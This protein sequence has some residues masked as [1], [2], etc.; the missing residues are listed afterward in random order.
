M[1]SRRTILAAAAALP[2][3]RVATARAA[4]P[5][6]AG[7]RIAFQLVRHGDVIGRHELAF[8]SDGASLVV[9]IAV[10]IVVKFGPIPVYRYRHRGTERWQGDRFAGFDS[11]TDS[12]GTPHHM[13]AVA[14]G[15]TITVEGSARP[16]Y[17]APAH[18]LPSTY[19]NPAMLQRHV[20]SSEDGQ[21]FDVTPQK[22]GDD[23]VRLAAGGSIRAAHWKLDA[24]LPLDLWY[25]VAGQWAHMVF[26]KDGST[27]TY[28][29]L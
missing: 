5:V 11:T 28:E 27:I 7:G 21:L 19:W 29:K 20:I 6:P 23:S 13:R 1:I 10:D 9:S 2:S 26:T 3:A 14:D 8:R 24:G 25:D 18:S 15:D 12:D 4:L 22:L 16:R 17:V